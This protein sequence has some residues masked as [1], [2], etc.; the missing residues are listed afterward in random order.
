M[1]LVFDGSGSLADWA[2]V[3][4][5]ISAAIV[6]LFL[7]NHKKR[8]KLIYDPRFRIEIN[9]WT[10]VVYNPGYEPVFLNFT[11]DVNV[12][13]KKNKTIYLESYAKVERYEEIP[14]IFNKEKNIAKVKIREAVSKHNYY[15][16]L[17]IK[18]NKICIF[19]SRNKY[20]KGKKVYSSVY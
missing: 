16:T 1:F 20:C 3:F 13:N 6:S 15:L 19:E 8:P 5:T 4:G 2:S 11:G 7:A 10:L 18:E 9:N 17:V 14:I 12:E